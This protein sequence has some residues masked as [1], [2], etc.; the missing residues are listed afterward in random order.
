MSSNREVH[1]DVLKP[2]RAA[3]KSCISPIV[4]KFKDRKQQEKPKSS[5]ESILGRE[6]DCEVDV[7]G[8]EPIQICQACQ[9]EVISGRKKWNCP[10]CERKY[11]SCSGMYQHMK[12]HH[13][14]HK[15]N[16]CPQAFHVNV[17]LRSHIHRDHF[18]LVFPR[19]PCE[20]CENTYADI[21]GLGNHIKHHHLEPSIE[22]L[23]KV[24]LK[25]PTKHCIGSFRPEYQ[26]SVKDVLREAEDLFMVFDG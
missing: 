24:M 22:Y 26:E 15:C 16:L 18:G 1:P 8:A 14:D 7:P 12:R 13:L 11:G 9:C 25:Y 20:L 19:L 2:R 5:D 21:G 10:G 6:E 17:R 3:R 23:E 4:T